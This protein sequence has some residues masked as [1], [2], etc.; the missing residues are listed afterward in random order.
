[1]DIQKDQIERVKGQEEATKKPV[2]NP[3]EILHEELAIKDNGEY[4]KDNGKGGVHEV[5]E[6]MESNESE[7]SGSSVPLMM[8]KM[9]F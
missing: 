4:F 1:M 3:F 6:K 5:L 7:A 2:K 8:L 9:L